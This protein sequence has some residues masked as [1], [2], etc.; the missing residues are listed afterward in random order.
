MS[1]PPPTFFG[2][3]HPSLCGGGTLGEQ[4]PQAELTTAAFLDA[5]YRFVSV[6]A[7]TLTSTLGNAVGRPAGCKIGIRVL[8]AGDPLQRFILSGVGT[9]LRVTVKQVGVGALPP[10]EA[11]AVVTH[12]ADNG[13]ALPLTR[14]QLRKATRVRAA[15]R[16]LEVAASAA[17]LTSGASGGGGGGA[18]S[19]R[20]LA[21]PGPVLPRA[22]APA[23]TPPLLPSRYFR[24]PPTAS[25][26]E[27]CDAAAVFLATQPSAGILLSVVGQHVGTPSPAL[28]IHEILL[29]DPLQRF[30]F[31]KVQSTLRI[32]L[33]TLTNTQAFMSTLLQQQQQQPQQQQ[34]LQ[35][36]SSAPPVYNPED[37]NLYVGDDEA[38]Y[39][40]L[41]MR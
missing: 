15:A 29:H 20:S 34:P 3:N 30:E 26:A 32:R 16:L 6:R 14:T 2:R 22:T 1:R 18:P 33:R 28:K 19:S 5:A 4:P 35:H 41:L 37:D 12:P 25:T 13:F 10:I 8:L 17:S 38:E 36:R 39:E 21:A 23:A 11:A 9:D 24:P 31:L 27:S 7:P 40:A